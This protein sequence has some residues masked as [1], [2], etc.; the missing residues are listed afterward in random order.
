MCKEKAMC[1][2]KNKKKGNKRFNTKRR[3]A[4]KVAKNLK[5]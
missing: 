1:N 2:S 3:I 5:Y 4:N